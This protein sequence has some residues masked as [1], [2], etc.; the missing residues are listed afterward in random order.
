MAFPSSAPPKT[1]LE[2]HRQLAPTASV[3][4][5]PL[6]LGA[7]N[8]GDAHKFRL[9][10]CSK[11]TSFEILDYFVSQGGNFIDTANGYQDGQSER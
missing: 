3:R 1:L 10:E 8:F 4:V 5:S 7:M 11:E 9:G 6:C 2:R